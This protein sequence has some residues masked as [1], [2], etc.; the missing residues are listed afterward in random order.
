MALSVG[1]IGLAHLH[2]T[3]Y[4]DVMSRMREV[5]LVACWDDDASRGKAAAERFGMRFVPALD[6]LLGDGAIDAVIIGSPTN[7]HAE[8]TVKAA[9]AGKHI[10]CQKPM[11]L[12]LDDCDRMIAAV[13]ESGVTFSMAYQ[14][15]HDPVNRAMRAMVREG[16]LGRIGHAR[17]RHCIPV[18]F[19]RDF[20]LGATKWHIDPIQNMGMFMDDASHAADWF[21]WTFGKPASVVAEIGSVLTNVAPDDTGVAIYRFS[22]SDHVAEGMMGILLNSSVTH[23]AMNTT[24][25]YGDEGVL[26]QD[27]GDG[28]S[29]ALPRPPDAR[30][31]RL[32]RVAER[33]RGWQ[34]P[35]LPIPASHGERIAAV[36]GP[37]VEC[38]L[39]GAPIPATAEEGRVAV[40][41]ILGAYESA[42]TGRRVTFPY[43]QER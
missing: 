6:D 42:R 5:K 26:I 11:A 15:R 7:R 20:V 25:I 43:R 10:L 35:D 13:R 8:H 18:L 33:E 28:P 36:P 2:V 4:A 21:T 14:M 24:E 23:V 31:V 32:F 19:S 1:F 27:Y 34:F 30:P 22:G 29:M 9:R 38:L 16:R 40:E 41:M 12:T 3:T 39:R 37:F 17:R